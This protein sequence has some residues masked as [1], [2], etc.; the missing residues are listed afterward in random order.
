MVFYGIVVFLA[1]VYEHPQVKLILV[2]FLIIYLDHVLQ[3]QKPCA[4]E[5]LAED[6]GKR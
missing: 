6:P 2:R 4:S 3:N 5:E 1:I